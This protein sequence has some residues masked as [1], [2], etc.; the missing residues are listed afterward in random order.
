[1][2]I[3]QL[4]RLAILGRSAIPALTKKF[5]ELVAATNEPPKPSFQFFAGSKWPTEEFYVQRNIF[6]SLTLRHAQLSALISY[7]QNSNA[8]EPGDAVGILAMA[9]HNQLIIIPCCSKT[10]LVHRA[11]FKLLLPMP[12]LHFW[13]NVLSAIPVLLSEDKTTMQIHAHTLRWP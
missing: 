2:A 10:F 4:V 11:T 13:N 6:C 8:K 1:M 5:L 12:W 3:F 7:L 9:G